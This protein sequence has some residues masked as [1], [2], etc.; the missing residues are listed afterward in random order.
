[1]PLSWVKK[2]YIYTCT[3]IY[4]S[5]ASGLY[6]GNLWKSRKIR[7]KYGINWCLPL[8]LLLPS[9]NDLEW[10][11]EHIPGLSNC[12]AACSSE[13]LIQPRDICLLVAGVCEWWSKHIIAVVWQT[14]YVTREETW[15]SDHILMGNFGVEAEA[16]QRSVQGIWF[17]V[18]A[19]VPRY[20][21]I[22][23]KKAGFWLQV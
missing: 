4:L 23:F 15:L 3:Y 14:C 12:V 13:T 5:R 19:M 9:R 6:T 8:V 22:A 16:Q 7:Y 10:V 11:Y 17:L 20:P 2:K 21:V 18:E 1:M